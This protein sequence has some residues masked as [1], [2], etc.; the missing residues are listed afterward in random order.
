VSY[1]IDYSQQARQD[2]RNMPARFRN[3]VRSMIEALSN[4]PRPA[5]S[6]ELRDLTGLYRLRLEQWRIIYAIDDEDVQ[7]QIIR[8]KRKTGPETYEHLDS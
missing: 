5:R 6:K 8:I 4:D 2:L 3:R 7:I 1:R